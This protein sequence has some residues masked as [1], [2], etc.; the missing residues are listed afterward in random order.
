MSVHRLRRTVPGLSVQSL[1]AQFLPAV[2][3]ESHLHPDLM[4]LFRSHPT[5]RDEFIAVT[6]HRTDAVLVL[7]Q[8]QHEL[9]GKAVTHKYESQGDTAID[10]ALSQGEL[11]NIN[12]QS[13]KTLLIAF[14]QNYSL[15]SSRLAVLLSHVMLNE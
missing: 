11:Y 15:L 8:L 2:V 4:L 6:Q 9:L 10:T 12:Y 3:E 14:I 1:D 7:R 5:L 13:Y